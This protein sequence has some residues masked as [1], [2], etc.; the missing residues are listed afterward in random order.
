MHGGYRRLGE[1]DDDIVVMPDLDTIDAST[2]STDF[3]GHSYFGDNATVMSDLIYVIRKG[4]PV[5]LRTYYA[6][7]PVQAAIGQ[8]W[9]FK[10]H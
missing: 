2:V 1:S 3:L 6:L 10:A 4:T 7:E 5:Q 8:H 9:R